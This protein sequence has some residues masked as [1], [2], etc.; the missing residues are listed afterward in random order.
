MLLMSS[1]LIDLDHLFAEPVYDPGRCSIG[2]HPLHE[3]IPVLL[4]AAMCIPAKTRLIGIGLVIHI[5]LDSIDCQVTNN[6]WFV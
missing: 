4:Y 1:M 5:V 6:V 2:F 3:F